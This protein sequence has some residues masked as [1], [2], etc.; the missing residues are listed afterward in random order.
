MIVEKILLIIFL[1]FPVF[2]AKTF[3]EAGYKSYYA[4]L[5]IF[6][7]YIWLKVVSKP[8]WWFVFLLIPFINFFMI[9]LLV[10]E[11]AKCY[12]KYKLGQQALAVVLFFYMLPRYGFSETEQYEDPQNRPKIKKSA[13]REWVDAIIFAVVA[14]SIIR[15]FLVEA[16]TIPTSSMEKS[17]LVGDFLFVSK[18]S[19]GPRA[20]MT[21]ISFP[22]V[23]H[24]LPLTK[25]TKSYTEL[26][27]FPYYRF[28]GLTDVNRNDVVVF[29]FPV[30]DT[31]SER[32]QSNR[33][34]YSL[35]REYGRESVRNNPR[36]FGDIIYRPVDKRENFIKRCV[37][38]PGDTLEIKDKK[39]FINEE[40]AE[41]PGKLQ[42]NYIVKTNG[43]R[44]N[45]RTLDRLNVTEE[46]RNLSSNEYMMTLTDET[47][48][49]IRNFKIVKHVQAVNR[50]E[51]VREPYIYPHDSAYN[52]NVDNFG[53][54]YIP[55]KGS[56]VKLN[57]Q[58]IALWERVI[59]VYEDNDL[60]VEG[61]DIYINDEKTDTY[62]F[63]M[64][65]YWMMGDNRHN[66][67]D[68]RFWGF[69]PENHVVGKAIFVWLSLAPD[70]PLFEKVR[71]NKMFR[72]VK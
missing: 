67:A 37:G 72:T 44:I 1:F 46:V 17:L 60:R 38:L 65:Y 24:T 70:E 55:K 15:M 6:N 2:V 30:G 8:L 64:N 68:S 41:V 57:S 69:V 48:E 39:L 26:V 11:T 12:Q 13:T 32:F 36:R 9:F 21:P 19:Y 16:Y 34:Y 58:N 7:Y 28:A 54:M 25:N 47:A 18:I 35:V 52:W 51:D 66:S 50:P 53:P 20:P 62:T 29:N 71:W 45:P 23:H 3:S 33:S 43:S 42:Y 63:K 56:T 14:A 49:K 10:V 61:D 4:F 5:P 31:V 22:F 59:D 27:K 40:P